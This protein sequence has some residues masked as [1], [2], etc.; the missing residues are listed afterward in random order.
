VSCDV[1]CMCILP[2]SCYYNTGLVNYK[3]C[4][5]C[6]FLYV[7]VNNLSLIYIL[8]GGQSGFMRSCS[9]PQSSRRKAQACAQLSC[10]TKSTNKLQRRER[11]NEMAPKPRYRAK[12]GYELL[13]WLSGALDLSGKKVWVASFLLDFD[14]HVLALDG[15]QRSW[16]M[17]D[18][19]HKHNTRRLPFESSYVSR[20]CNY[21]VLCTA[22][23]LNLRLGWVR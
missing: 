22:N 20:T 23:Q 18:F 8:Y 21:W 2:Y 12:I 3:G 11:A 10:V 5:C 13:Y 14:R 9:R 6:C 17:G 1:E 16:A 15:G 4:A 7:P 19:I